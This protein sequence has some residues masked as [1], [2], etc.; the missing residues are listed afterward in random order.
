MAHG[1]TCATLVLLTF[2]VLSFTSIRA[3]LHTNWIA[4]GADAAYE[5]ALVRMPGWQ[6]MEMEGYDLLRD[7][8]GDEQVAPRAW[9][10]VGSLVSSYRV[11]RDDEGGQ[12]VGV[13]G[14]LG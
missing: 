2:S 10:S 1:L 6:A 11:E 3:A 14:L 4:I 7:W 13:W 12:A 5:G 9:L 8:F